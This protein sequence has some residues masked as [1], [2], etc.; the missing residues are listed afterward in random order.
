MAEAAFMPFLGPP[1]PKLPKLDRTTLSC[2]DFAINESLL[3]NHLAEW[4]S[5]KSITRINIAT[6]P[7]PMNERS[8]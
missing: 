4:K 6:V 8:Y 7:C 5:G 3:D 2:L 1:M